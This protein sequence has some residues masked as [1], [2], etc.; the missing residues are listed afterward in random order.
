MVLLTTSVL[1]V[2][3]LPAV[4]VSNL[5]LEPLS[6]LAGQVSEIFQV[7]AHIVGVDAV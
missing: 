3:Q 7:K 4:V 2:A 5:F 6:R 1:V